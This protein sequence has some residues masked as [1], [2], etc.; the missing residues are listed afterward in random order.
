MTEQYNNAPG[1]GHRQADARTELNPA[2]VPH[3]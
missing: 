2:S 3:C 1:D